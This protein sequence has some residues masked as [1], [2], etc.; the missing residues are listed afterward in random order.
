[1]LGV[2]PGLGGNRYSGME[3]RGGRL[4]KFGRR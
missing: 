2:A 3:E 1:M 4:V